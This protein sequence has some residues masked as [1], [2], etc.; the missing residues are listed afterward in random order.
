MSRAAVLF[1]GLAL[2]GCATVT[3][4]P[5]PGA[6][7]APD[8]RPLAA[9]EISNACWKLLMCAPLGSGDPTLPNEVSCRLFQNTTTVASQ[10]RM[11]Q[12]EAIRLGAT[13][14]VEVSTQVS[15]EALF[16]FL[17][18]RE[19]IHTSAILVKDVAPA[20]PAKNEGLK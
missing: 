5:D 12:D 10:M 2:A 19:K 9:V 20:A 13:R 6:V 8:V 16:F 11:L 15:E 1:L 7:S 3:R 18:Q 17:L 14:A 4:L